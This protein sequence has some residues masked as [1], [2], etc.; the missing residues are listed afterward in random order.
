VLCLEDATEARG[1][2]AAKTRL[3]CELCQVEFVLS[4]EH[5]SAADTVLIQNT[6]RASRALIGAIHFPAIPPSLAVRFVAFPRR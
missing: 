5:M 6:L 1:R 2:G 4:R 3:L